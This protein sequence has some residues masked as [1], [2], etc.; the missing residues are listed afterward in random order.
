MLFSVDTRDTVFNCGYCIL[1][2]LVKVQ[3][4]LSC[5]I[6]LVLKVLI[7]IYEFSSVILQRTNSENIIL[8]RI[9]L[10]LT[11]IRVSS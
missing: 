10:C 9:N 3:G 11:M 8:V 1:G 5:K 2:Y 4:E 6:L 7:V